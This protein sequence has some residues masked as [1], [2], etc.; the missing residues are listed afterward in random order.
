[1]PRIPQGHQLLGFVPIVLAEFAIGFSTVAY[2]FLLRAMAG[3][4]ADEVRHDLHQ[5]RTSLIF[6]LVTTTSKVGAA[7]RGSDVLDPS[8]ARLGYHAAEGAVNARAAVHDLLMLYLL[9][10]LIFLALGAATFRGYRLDSDRH[11]LIREALAQR[12]QN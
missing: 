4:V 11:S 1:M 7:L 8:L 2:L 6:S 5:D 10:P 12:A 9:A 3:D